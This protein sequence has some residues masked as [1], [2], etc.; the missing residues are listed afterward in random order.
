MPCSSFGVPHLKVVWP[1]RR[2]ME[3]ALHDIPLCHEGANWRDDQSGLVHGV[4]GTTTKTSDMSQFEGHLH[5]EE[6]RMNADW[7]L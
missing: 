6:S 3:E 2:P 4:I 5:D 7:G 1:L